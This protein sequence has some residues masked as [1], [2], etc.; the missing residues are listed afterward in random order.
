MGNAA[1]GE[2]RGPFVN[3]VALRR[4]ADGSSSEILHLSAMIDVST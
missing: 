1:G 3:P 4:H 2:H